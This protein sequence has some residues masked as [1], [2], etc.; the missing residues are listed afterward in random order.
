[1]SFSRAFQWYH[2][3]L[4]PIWPDGTFKSGGAGI[5]FVNLE[6]FPLPECINK[7]PG[8][9]LPLRRIPPPS[10]ECVFPIGPKWGRDHILLR[11]RRW[12]DPIRTNGTKAWH[13]VYSMVR[14]IRS[15]LHL[16]TFT[17][18]RREGAFYLTFPRPYMSSF[19]SME[20]G[21][22]IFVSCQPLPISHRHTSSW[23]N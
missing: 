17:W 1:M 8:A 14:F 3:H 2:S 13:S 20:K 16:L 15:H 19:A 21:F 10:S 18:C 7:S 22:F 9:G 6:G 11:V 12:G 4:D 23:V 5:F